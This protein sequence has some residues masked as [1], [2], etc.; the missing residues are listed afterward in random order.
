MAFCLWFSLAAMSIAIPV[1]AVL[2]VLGACVLTMLLPA[3][4]GYI[5]AFQIAFVI[6]LEPYGV[7]R[8]VALAASF[9]YQFFIS[10]PLIIVGLALVLK[11]G[12]SLEDWRTAMRGGAG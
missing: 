7:S 1:P 6:T 11:D 3:A 9:F 8:D 10:V 5:G 2:V 4:P 12:Y